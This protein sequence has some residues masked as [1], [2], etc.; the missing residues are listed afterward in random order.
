MPPRRK[1][2]KKQTGRVDYGP[3]RTPQE[4]GELFAVVGRI[5]GGENMGVTCSDGIERLCII[6]RKF[7]G[8][9]KRSNEVTTGSLV[10]VGLYDWA[11]KTQGKKQK[12]DLLHI[13]SRDQTRSFAKQGLLDGNVQLLLAAA[14]DAT[15]MDA[16]DDA[17]EFSHDGMEQPEENLDVSTSDSEDNETDA[18]ASAS[19]VTVVTGAEVSVDDI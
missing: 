2:Q 6:R 1:Q 9:H 11:T 8:R 10:L 16:N 14:G 18:S 7:R 5:F 15:A 19:A 12:C 3:A 17:L 13:Y 4:A